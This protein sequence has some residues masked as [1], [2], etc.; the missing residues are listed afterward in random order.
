MQLAMPEVFTW[1]LVQFHTGDCQRS[2]ENGAHRT[3]HP[4]PKGAMGALLFTVQTTHGCKNPVLAV[5]L[6]LSPTVRENG[7]APHGNARGARRSRW[8]LEIGHVLSQAL[9]AQTRVVRSTPSQAVH[10]FCRIP[11]VQSP[12]VCATSCRETTGLFFG[13]CPNTGWLA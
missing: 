13:G 5:L 7:W 10:K 8:S 6:D 4:H 11:L 9:Q 1:G 2:N 3:D 12:T